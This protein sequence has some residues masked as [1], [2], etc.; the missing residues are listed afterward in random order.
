MRG[1]VAEVGA[2][3][4]GGWLA[5]RVIGQDPH[6]E[7]RPELGG[8]PADAAVADHAHGGAVQVADRDRAA[9]G[10]AALTDQRG[11]RAE[12]LDQV[13]GH[14]DG[15]FG[16][17]GGAGPRG[18][19][20]GDAAGGRGRDVDQV[21]AHPG[22]GDDPERGRLIE[23]RLVDP[24]V[25]ADDGAGGDG[26]FGLTRGGDEPAVPVEHIRDQR[27]VDRPQPDHDRQALVR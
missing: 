23:Q 18:D 2:A 11:E 25:G 17:R 14:A 4:V 6:P 19:H 22:P 13:Q 5:G 10:P 12:P 1:E 9:L 24:G 3:H 26:E 16:H 15:A 8:A 20:H 21:G 27:R 7:G